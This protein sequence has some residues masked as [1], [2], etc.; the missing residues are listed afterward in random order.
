[1]NAPRDPFRDDDIELALLGAVAASPHFMPL[2]GPRVSESD[3]GVTEHG[4]VWE[5]YSS[6]LAANRPITLAT[7]TVEL[8]RR[9]LI[10]AVSSVVSL[11]VLPHMAAT[12]AQAEEYAR[13]VAENG[14][15]R[16]TARAAH[17]V[18]LAAQ[19]ERDPGTFADTA[20]REIANAAQSSTALEYVPLV[21]IAL[22]YDTHLD[23]SAKRGDMI[24]GATTGLFDLD[25]VTAGMRGGQ[26]IIVAA[27]PAMGKTAFAMKAAK[28]VAEIMSERAAFF[29]L[30]MTRRELWERMVCETASVDSM[31]VKLRTV[32]SIDRDRM[33]VASQHLSQLPVE[34]Y[35]R[36]GLTA[37]EIRAACLRI[38]GAR[39][40]GLVVVDYLGLVNTNTP[41]LA[42]ESVEQRTG[43]TALKF[44]ELAKELDVPVVLLAQLNRKCEE[45][46]DKRP[47]PSDLRDSGQLEQHADAIWFLYRDE[48]YDYAS[49]YKGIAEVIISKQRGGSTGVVHVAY[50]KTLTRFRDMNEGEKMTVEQLAQP[51]QEEKPSRRGR[52]GAAS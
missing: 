38:K 7:L 49:K 3:M 37:A 10:N 9:G 8:K 33:R 15:A 47:M 44:K 25:K 20:A 40:L 18:T 21:E 50:E 24:E 34:I 39:G 45:R 35:D 30:E 28:S 12:L 1:M 5:C 41:D 13:I 31:K 16:R 52:Y 32:D 22:E 4:N 23:E 6:L 11:S 43:I 2:V 17:R 42:G 36:G 19:S 27:R 26:L 14:R 48:V 46:P 51:A 29:S